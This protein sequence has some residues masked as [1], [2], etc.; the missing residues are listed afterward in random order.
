MLDKTCMWQPFLRRYYPD[1]VHGFPQLRISVD[2]GL[3]HIVSYTPRGSGKYIDK[4]E[5]LA[6]HM[7]EIT[8][9]I[10]RC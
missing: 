8:V 3:S 4:P 10:P 9:V 2:N 1:Q 5:L 6:I 7:N